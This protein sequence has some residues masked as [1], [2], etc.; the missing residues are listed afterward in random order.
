M[1]ERLISNRKFNTFLTF[2][3]IFSPAANNDIINFI[4][5]NGGELKKGSV[6]EA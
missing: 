5:E 1:E 3:N 2:T 6:P 4:K